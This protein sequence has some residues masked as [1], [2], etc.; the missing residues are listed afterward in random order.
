MDNRKI[1]CISGLGADERIFANVK[2][3]KA[4][5]VYLPWPAFDK[6]DDLAA[7]AQK[8]SA[9]IKEDNPTILGVSFG[10][11]LAVEMSKVRKVNK[12]IIVSSAKTGDEVTH[13]TGL[14]KL[15]IVKRLI[16]AFMFTWPHPF[17]LYLFGAKTDEEK[18][19]MRNI[20]RS[21][22]GSL[23]QWAMKAI[24]LWDNKIYTAN[25]VHIHGDADKV[26]DSKQ[27]HPNY[28]IKGGSHMMIYDMADEINEIINREL[29]IEK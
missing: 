24:Q 16:P 21:S 11:M 6:N 2:I 22:D 10:G 15:V 1:Y 23:V 29:A 28:W 13:F 8:V 27:V 20:I 14:N 18:E 3:N 19:L 9:L 26:I 25:I 12:A 7:Y 17:I 4:T 5:L